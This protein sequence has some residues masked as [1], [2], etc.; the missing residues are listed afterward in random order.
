[1][2]GRN[3]GGFYGQ[4]A[5]VSADEEEYH[6]EMVP[7]TAQEEHRSYIQDDPSLQ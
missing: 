3:D 4:Q 6:E 2:I 7:N 1:M 5:V